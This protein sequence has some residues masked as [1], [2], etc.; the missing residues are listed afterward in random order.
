[1]QD[2]MQTLTSCP[3]G[4]IAKSHNEAFEDKEPQI[5]VTSRMRD[6]RP[7]EVTSGTFS[8][9]RGL[10]IACDLKTEAQELPSSIRGNI[11]SQ[12]LHPGLPLR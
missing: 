2:Y 7:L 4:G 5:A 3:M 11:A 12:T 8:A 6:S 10:I 9:N 1:M